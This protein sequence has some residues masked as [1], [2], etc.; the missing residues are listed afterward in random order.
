MTWLGDALQNEVPEEGLA[1]FIK[2]LFF[3]RPA[4]GWEKF[5]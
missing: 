3:A 1:K 5:V 2:A 4:I